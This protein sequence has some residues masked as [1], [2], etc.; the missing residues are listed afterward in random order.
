MFTQKSILFV[1]TIAAILALSA[2]GQ[3][4]VGFE[5][6]LPGS[7]GQPVETIETAAPTNLPQP[8]PTTEASPY[9]KVVQDPQ[10]G[11]RFAVP[12]S[13]LV[14]FPP[15]YGPGSG[16]M[17]YSLTNYPADF[18]LS[19]PRGQGIFEAGGIKIDMNFM[20]AATWGISP[21]ASLADFVNGLYGEGSEVTVVA[22]EDLMING[23]PTLKVTT[24]SS[25]GPGKFYLLAVS[26]SIYLLYAPVLEAAEHPD[27]LAVLNSITVSADAA[28]P[29]PIFDPGAPPQ[30]L[31][32]SC[33]DNP[34]EP[35]TFSQELT[36][37]DC[38]DIA[39]GSLEWTACNVQDG[40]RSRNL[41]AL[42]GYMV[43][44]FN[45]GYWG[46][47]GRKVSPQAVLEEI[48]TDRLPDDPSLVPT[49]TIDRDLFPPLAEQ[50]VE[51]MFGPGVSPEL[52]VYSEGWGKDQTG[53]ALLYFIKNEAGE[54]KWYGLI[55]SDEHFNLA[56]Q[57]NTL[58]GESSFSSLEAL[59]LGIQQGLQQRD[60]GMLHYGYY[61]HEPFTLGYWASEG[62]TMTA[63]EFASNLANQLLPLDPGGLTFIDDSAA[64][65]PL[66]GMP[67]NQ[68]FGPD[69]NVARTI[70]SE[71]WGADGLGAA[72]IYLAQ[73]D[74]Q[75]YYWH[76][77]GFSNQHFDK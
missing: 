1:L 27:V 7:A 71:G 44:P 13:W 18:V 20:D 77:L 35:N 63:S 6:P 38:A 17:S 37:L 55:Y 49:F 45:I 34:A 24:E 69:L 31:A 68:M 39:P 2:C 76:G 23:Q 62:V 47:E 15:G 51:A 26:E 10:Y 75:G 58:C 30:G 25:F 54:F 66:G 57:T 3:V 61:I 16:A 70:Y 33:L 14:N 32:A 9:W 67:V 4:E 21:G 50:D 12:C 5:P 64:F 29:V 72:I 60:I 52:V 8:T 59:S 46:S 11:V 56:V 43:D 42:V 73:D 40:I 74:C 28:V 48:Q 22:T 19:F 41:S 36:G 65:P 53:S